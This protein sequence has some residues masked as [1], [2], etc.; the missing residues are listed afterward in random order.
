MVRY[1]VA[2]TETVE[3]F[4]SYDRRA[5]AVVLARQQR[6]YDEFCE[7]RAALSDYREGVRAKLRAK[8]RELLKANMIDYERLAACELVC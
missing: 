5:Y 7:H 4:G 3:V 1:T 2:E 8:F 6:V